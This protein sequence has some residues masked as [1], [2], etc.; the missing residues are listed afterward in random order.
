MAVC[1]LVS[2]EFSRLVGPMDHGLR[3]QWGDL[4]GHRQPP[5]GYDS[6]RQ[7]EGIAGTALANKRSGFG[8]LRKPRIQL[9]CGASIHL[10]ALT[11]ASPGER[12]TRQR[13]VREIAG[14]KASN[15]ARNGT[16]HA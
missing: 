11:L 7:F 9:G 12:R 2:S 13:L 3:L 5:I 14:N 10:Q 4:R 15:Y 16:K 8:R 6:G 1:N